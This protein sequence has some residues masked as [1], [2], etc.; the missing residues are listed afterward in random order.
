[1]PKVHR[2]NHNT[3]EAQISKTNFVPNLPHKLVSLQPNSRTAFVP[4]L[5]HKLSTLCKPSSQKK[6][7]SITLISLKKTQ[8]IRRNSFNLEL[9]G[10]FEFASVFFAFMKCLLCLFVF[11][12]S[13]AK[14][15]TGTLSFSTL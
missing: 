3:H 7:V 13:F 9:K 14:T 4:N 6:L 10:N 2:Q 5:F 8:D 12:V 1:M 15:Q 11:V